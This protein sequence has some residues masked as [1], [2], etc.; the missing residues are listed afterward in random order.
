MLSAHKR[1]TNGEKGLEGGEGGGGGG[2]VVVCN[3]YNQL[4]RL[5]T[6]LSHQ[7]AQSGGYRLTCSPEQSLLPPRTGAESLVDVFDY[8]LALCHVMTPEQGAVGGREGQQ[9]GRGSGP[10]G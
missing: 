6:T 10:H 9:D 2:T 8:S 4:A 3:D 7:C 5:C 1:G